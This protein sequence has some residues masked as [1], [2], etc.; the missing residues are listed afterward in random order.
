MKKLI[1][2]L[3][4]V[5][6]LL[7]CQ[8]NVQAQSV[9]LGEQ[10]ET[11]SSIESSLYQNPKTKGKATYT[12]DLLGSKKEASSSLE[13]KSK[14]QKKQKKQASQTTILTEEVAEPELVVI[15]EVEEPEVV[16]VEEVAE[17]EVVVVEEVAEPEVVVVEKPAEPEVVVVEEVAEPEVV[18]VKEEKVEDL[19]PVESSLAKIPRNYT[20]FIATEVVGKDSRLAWISYKYYGVKDFWVYIYEANLDQVSSPN[21]VK[22]GQK[23]RIPALD[24]KYTDLNDPEVQKLLLYLSQEYTKH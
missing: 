1:N 9:A 21:Y 12:D 5:C 19:Q 16:V 4:L 8:H 18:V 22:P 23:L 7:V 14:K 6:F 15:E 24:S 20:K 3:M 10:S 17:P 13:N 11:V 2:T